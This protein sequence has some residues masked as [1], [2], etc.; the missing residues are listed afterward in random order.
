MI[1]QTSRKR[2][3]RSLKAT[4]QRCARYCHRPIAWQW[5]QLSRKLLGHHHYYGVR[6][7]YVALA[8]FRQQVWKLWGS[9]LSRRS[10]RVRLHRL[11]LLI[12]EQFVLPAPRITH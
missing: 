8:R 5:A 6:G 4:R 12:T 10:Q 2:L 11:Y 7:N 1:R 9:A 3:K